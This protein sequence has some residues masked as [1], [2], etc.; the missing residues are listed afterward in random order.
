MSNYPALAEPVAL[1]ALQLPHRVI[2]SS[3]T[4]NRSLPTTVPNDDNVKYYAQRANPE[5]GASLI[6][7]EGTLIS[8]Q[9]TEWPYAPGIWD[10]THAAGWKKVTDAVHAQGGQIVAQIWHTGRVCHPDMPEQSVGGEP[11]WAP[12]AIGARGG[13]FRLLPGRPGYISNPTP[14]PD[15]T[16]ILDQ[17]TNAAKMAKLADFD[18]VELH[19]GNG[20]LCE[21]FLSDVSNARTD[22]WGGSVENRARFGLEATKRLIDVWGADRVGIKISPLGG[23]NDTYNT[24]PE[25]RIETFKYYVSALDDLSLA[26]IQ[27]MASTFGDPCHGG[28]PQGFDHDIFEHYGP[29]IKKSNLI[30]NAEFD[31]AKGEEAVKSGKAKA[32]VFG[33]PFVANPD[34]YSRA[35]NGIALAEPDVRSFYLHRVQGVNG[36]GYNDYPVATLS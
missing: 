35:Q 9:G 1:G 15:P 29:L 5:T 25:S 13:K 16:V 10:E 36:S 8:H 28:V 2:M 34:F 7:S 17:F 20:Y 18:G 11:V 24:T 6:L 21:Q 27:I 14:I 33:R 23:Y 26:Y 19:S 4:R 30:A 22:K 32:I 31:A 12:S 3:L